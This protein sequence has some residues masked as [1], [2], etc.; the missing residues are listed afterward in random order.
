MNSIVWLSS[1]HVVTNV[2]IIKITK[3][4]MFVYELSSSQKLS[5]SHGDAI[6]L[7]EK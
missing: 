1:V 2:S 4:N 5:I 6:V 3:R 7:W